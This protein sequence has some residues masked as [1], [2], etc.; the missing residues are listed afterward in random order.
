[1]NESFGNWKLKVKSAVMI[2]SGSFRELSSPNIPEGI[3]IEITIASV[4]LI[5]FI[6]SAARPSAFRASPDPKIA[7]TII[8]F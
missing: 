5:D 2:V 6:T 3:S 7:S 8:S 1:M 4:W